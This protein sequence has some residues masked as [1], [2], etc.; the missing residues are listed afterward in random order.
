MP[1]ANKAWSHMAAQSLT[2]KA[3]ARRHVAHA[4]RSQKLYNNNETIK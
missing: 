4:N 2:R 3:N 1:S